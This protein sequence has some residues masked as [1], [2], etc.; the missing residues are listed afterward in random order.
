MV[1]RNLANG[2]GQL[3]FALALVLP[4][5]L[6]A[7]DDT[8]IEA[9]DTTRVEKN[10][11]KTQNA[12]EFTP[13]RGFTLF[14]S[15]MASLNI[16]V[17][18]LVRYTDQMPASQSFTDHLGRV[19]DI[20]TRR[21]IQWHRA[22]VWVSGHFFT[23]RFRYTVSLWGLG[24]TGQT[25]IFGNLQYRVHKAL[26]LAAGIGPNLGIRSLQG[27][28]PFF[29]GSDRQMVEEALRPGFT[30]GFWVTGEPLPGFNY[31]LMLGNNLSQ[32]GINNTQMTRHLTPS[33][34]VWWMPTTK[35]FGPR[36]GNGDLEM[37]QKVATRFGA[38]INHAREDRFN[39]ISNP[40]P[41]ETQIRLSDGVLFFET[42]A[43]ADN[44]TVKRTD[45][46]ITAFDAGLKYKGF[47]VQT[48]LIWRK[49]SKFDTDKALDVKEIV[50]KGF[51]ISL[52]YYI[53]KLKLNVYTVYGQLMDQFDRKPWE[54]TGGLSYYPSGTRNW[55]LNIHVINV[56]KSPAG[57]TFGYYVGGQTGT[58]FTL[59]IDFLL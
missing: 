29:N 26:T 51:D 23:P 8:K 10:I 22:F 53:S 12:G 47:H 58:T 13:G 14:N 33:A 49:L 5:K 54:I 39:E 44:V 36:G 20:D 52:S 35:E 50:D 37:H 31:W 16:S 7:Q 55:R 6:L 18:G 3:F 40:A 1:I 48:N 24:S 32:L 17:Y 11:Y 27:P 4:L 28:W 19:R 42:G 30:G 43:L 59:A 2:I 46:D 41:S 57:S 34:S 9:Y 15:K 21:D 56:H 38:S 45:Y 25:L